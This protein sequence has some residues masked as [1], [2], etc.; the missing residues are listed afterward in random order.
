MAGGQ[1]FGGHGGP[2]SAGSAATP[3]TPIGFYANGTG[4]VEVLAKVG[5]YYLTGRGIETTRT[6]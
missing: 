6:T 1:G 4:P 5:S 2:S 3:C